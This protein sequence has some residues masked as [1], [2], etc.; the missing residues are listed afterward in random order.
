VF[1][2]VARTDTAI[3]TLIRRGLAAVGHTDETELTAFTDGC[4]GLRSS[5]ADAGVTEPPFLDWFHI[6]LRLQHAETT[7]GTLPDSVRF[8]ANLPDV[9]IPTESSDSTRCGSR[10]FW[11]ET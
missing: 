1:A 3:E 10:T 11:R 7:A 8:C 4:S 2:A 6:A 5:L 9:V